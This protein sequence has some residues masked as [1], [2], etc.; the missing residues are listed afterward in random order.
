MWEYKWK[1]LRSF[2]PNFEI[3]NWDGKKSAGVQF[4]ILQKYNHYSLLNV[5]GIQ[6]EAREQAGS[7]NTIV[8]H[9]ESFIFFS[10]KKS[11][12]FHSGVCETFKGF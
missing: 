2:V 1:I 6:R 8:V 10:A 4:S 3:S 9:F 12:K 5:L 7:R 11:C